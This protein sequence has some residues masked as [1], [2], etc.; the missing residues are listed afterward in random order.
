MQKTI[1]LLALLLT[2][3]CVQAQVR[4]GKPHRSVKNNAKA[5]VA[6]LLQKQYEDHQPLNKTTAI[7][8]RLIAQSDYDTSFG[9][10]DSSA[11]KYSGQRGSSFNRQFMTYIQGAEPDFLSIG[12]DNAF[13]YSNSSGL[14]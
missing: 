4:P 8:E 5:F 9:I 3:I 10:I 1:S 13:G 14:R 2:C 6:Q 12:N 7:R 11:I